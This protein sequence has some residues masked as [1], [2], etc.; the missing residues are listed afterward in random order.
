VTLTAQLTLG[1]P[2]ITGPDAQTARDTATAT[3]QHTTEHTQRADEGP[4]T[5]E[6]PTG[7]EAP[8]DQADQTATGD[9]PATRDE[10]PPDEAAHAAS[11]DEAAAGHEPAAGGGGAGRPWA[12]AVGGQGLGAAFRISAA[13]DGCEIPGIGFID[14]ETIE[15]L[16]STVPLQVGRAL[17][18]ARTGTLLETTST[19]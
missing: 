4:T 11:I 2:V 17:L 10:A 18:D 19:A 9:E 5:T 7:D 13:L 3:A 12:P 1:I 8:P 16:L 6:A 15:A 14:A